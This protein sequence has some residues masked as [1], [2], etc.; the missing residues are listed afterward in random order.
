MIY[1]VTL[2]PSLDYCMTFPHVT[3]GAGQPRTVCADLSRRQRRQRFD[4]AG[5]LRD[6]DAGVWVLRRIYGCGTLPAAGRA[7]LPDGL[8]RNSGRDAHQRQAVFKCYDRLERCGTADSQ[9]SPFCPVGKTHGFKRGRH[10]GFSRRHS[11]RRTAGFLCARA[12]RRSVKR[13]PHR[14]GHFRPGVKAG[15][16]QPGLS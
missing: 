12:A 14:C 2:S 13:G 7:G 11:G 3:A 5:A 4:P 8:R 6:A 10:A 9:G 1:T 15:P 16:F